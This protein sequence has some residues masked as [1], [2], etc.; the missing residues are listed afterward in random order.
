VLFACALDI[1]VNDHGEEALLPGLTDFTQS[2]LFWIRNAH[3]WCHMYSIDS[4]RETMDDIKQGI[5][6]HTPDKY[7]LIGSLM[8]SDEF[9]KDFNCPNNSTMNPIRNCSIGSLWPQSPI[10]GV[11][12]KINE[13]NISMRLNNSVL[14]VIVLLLLLILEF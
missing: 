12:T 3:Q 5:D 10:K 11:K 4:L 7:R 8:L 2:Q 6:N 9:A 13:Q 1:W 14:L